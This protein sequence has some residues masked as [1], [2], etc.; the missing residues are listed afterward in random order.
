MSC[1]GKLTVQ[2][3]DFVTWSR[4]VGVT[5]RSSTLNH[6]YIKDPTVLKDL[7]SNL[8]PLNWLNMSKDTYKV[9][10]KE[11]FLDYNSLLPMI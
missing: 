11:L 1:F 7:N 2:V 3:V 5:L 9:H 6:I 8:I 4:L 10:C